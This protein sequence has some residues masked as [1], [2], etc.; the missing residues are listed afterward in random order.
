MLFQY[1]KLTF[2]EEITGIERVQRSI[3]TSITMMKREISK[4]NELI[5]LK[6]CITKLKRERD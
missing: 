3:D 1:Q 2:I 5:G 6:Q 4:Q